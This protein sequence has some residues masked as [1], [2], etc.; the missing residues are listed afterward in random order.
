VR[1]GSTESWRD[2]FSGS[3][4]VVHRGAVVIR[5]SHGAA[6]RAGNCACL[7]TTSFQ[8]ASISKQMTAAAVLQLE[9]IGALS[10]D[11]R[12]GRW[13]PEIPR[14]RD[15]TVHQLLTH[16]S[17][18]KSW[19]DLPRLSLFRSTT[20][21]A[22]LDAFARARLAFVPGARFRYSSPGYVL[23]SHIV[24]QEGGRP[25]RDVLRAMFDSADMA[26]SGVGAHSPNPHRDGTG[27]RGGRARPSFDLVT[28]SRGA[29]DLWS[30]VDDL[31]NWNRALLGGLILRAATVER[32]LHPHADVPIEGSGAR[33]IGYGYGWITYDY[34]EG[35]MRFH[36]GQN[37]GFAGI[38][39]VFPDDDLMVIALSNE[40]LTD[41]RAIC[42]QL[43]AE[44]LRP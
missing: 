8:I 23:L 37:A 15:I 16:T 21:R 24:E 10:V 35:P 19:D 20:D 7:P 33:S 22:V 44:A 12:I 30:T 40:E 32:A 4:L 28:V 13:F 25:Y 2:A 6:N 29:G 39:A 26:N 27:Y 11:D 34:P 31:A 1:G 42:S 41:V 18:L 36:T 38:N 9:E 43:R 17:G 3:V 5:E 14:W